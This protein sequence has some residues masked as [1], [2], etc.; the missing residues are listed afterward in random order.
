V[1]GAYF[2][3][4][5]TGP[6]SLKAA[7]LF[8]AMLSPAERPQGPGRV[9]VQRA[10]V[11]QAMGLLAGAHHVGDVLR[12]DLFREHAGGGVPVIPVAVYVV[13]TLPGA[14]AS[15]TRD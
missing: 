14:E 5:G 8:E 13:A 1:R 7:L 15:N 12:A 2:P 4:T 11:R 3:Q 10:G 9:P 6:S